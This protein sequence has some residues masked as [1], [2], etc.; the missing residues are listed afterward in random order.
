MK[1]GADHGGLIA[2]LLLDIVLVYRALR[3]PPVT[4]AADAAQRG[5]VDGRRGTH[6]RPTSTPP[7]SPGTTDH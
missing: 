1:R 6:H 4:P 2:F 3:P 7:T 5:I